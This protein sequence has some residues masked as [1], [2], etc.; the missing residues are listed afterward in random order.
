MADKNASPGAMRETGETLKETG[1]K[2]YDSLKS[3]RECPTGKEPEDY[4]IAIVAFVVM[5]LAFAGQAVMHGYQVRRLSD[6]RDRDEKERVTKGHGE[7]I[8]AIV[9]ALIAETLA[10]FYYYRRVMHCDGMRGFIVF[11]VVTAMATFLAAT[12]AIPP[13]PCKPCHKEPERR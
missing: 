10:A 8:F 11:I 13:R 5:M 6:D 12:V 1:A 3:K 7:K 2:V 9:C 4:H